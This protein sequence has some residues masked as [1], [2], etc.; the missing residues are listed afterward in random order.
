MVMDKKTFNDLLDWAN[1]EQ[2]RVW[3]EIQVLK[4]TI[5]ESEQKLKRLTEAYSDFSATKRQLNQLYRETFW[6]Q[7]YVMSKVPDR[8]EP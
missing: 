1:D 7:D 4:N 5:Y 6:N 3:Q 2:G 8:H